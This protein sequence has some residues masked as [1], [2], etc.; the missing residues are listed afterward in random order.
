MNAYQLKSWFESL[1]VQDVTGYACNPIQ[2]LILRNNQRRFRIEGIWKSGEERTAIDLQ[3]I[4]EVRE[5]NQNR[6]MI[7]ILK[8]KPDTESRR[9]N[10]QEW[11]GFMKDGRMIWN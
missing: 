5:Q 6:E 7:T 1:M 9:I 11:L 3:E 8:P 10:Y 4:E 2:G